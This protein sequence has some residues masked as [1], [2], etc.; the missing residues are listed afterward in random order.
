MAVTRLG[1]RDLDVM[2]T[3]IPRLILALDEWPDAEEQRSV[4]LGNVVAQLFGGGKAKKKGNAKP[5]KALHRPPSADER[6]EVAKALKAAL[7]VKGRRN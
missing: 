4:A 7:G 1:W 3:P 5:P 2:Q 6:A